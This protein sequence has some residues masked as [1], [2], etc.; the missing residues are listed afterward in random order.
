MKRPSH[1]GFSLLELLLAIGILSI[2]IP[3]TGSI[4][5]TQ[6]TNKE[7]YKESIQ[8]IDIINDFYTFT[9]IESFDRIKQISEQDTPFYVID[10][11]EDGIISR[12]FVTKDVWMQT[13]ESNREY[14]TV[15]ISQ[16]DNLFSDDNDGMQPYL[17]LM[18]KLSK[19]C[20]NNSET[21]CAAF[22]AVKVY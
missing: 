13:D 18:C 4:F 21:N 15:R 22:V 5:Y 12:E 2:I 7:G 20:P 10:N 17:S 8:Q 6:I 1:K 3:A 19:L 16:I 14:Y 9:Q 11:E